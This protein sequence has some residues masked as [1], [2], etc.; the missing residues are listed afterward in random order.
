MKTKLVLILLCFF[1]F[2]G[3]SQDRN[4]YSFTSPA[5]APLMNTYPMMNGKPSPLKCS[6]VGGISYEQVAKPDANFQISRFE[7]HYGSSKADG[8]RL[9]LS[10]NG[11]TV[12][13]TCFDWQ[14]IPIAKF[15]NS[16]VTA[17]F[18]YFGKLLDDSLESIVLG[19]GGHILNYH[20]F[21]NNTLLGMR[22]MDM[23]L[24]YMYNFVSDLPKLNN[25]YILGNGESIPDINANRLGINNFRREIRNIE[26]SL[27]QNFRSYIITDFNRPVIISLN[28]DSL[29]LSGFPYYYCWR[30]KDENPAF[31]SA[32][33]RSRIAQNYKGIMAAQLQKNP[34]FSVRS[35]YME[36]LI[37]LAEIY[38]PYYNLY[39]GG[40]FVD[41]VNLPNDRTFRVDFLDRYDNS[42]LERLLME[43]SYD[44]E[45]RSIDFLEEFSNRM[46][47]VDLLQNTNPAVWNANVNI[48][49]YAAFF[50]YV[51]LNFPLKWNHFLTEL[52]N[53]VPQPVVE[54]YTVMYEPVTPTIPKQ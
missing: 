40:T 6:S 15:A 4:D 49:R 35:F 44:M 39:P 16:D 42:S 34:D 9:S 21:F 30:Y 19:N 29:Q 28:N 11:T 22:L 54:T 10:I 32:A 27:N 53:I 7:I 48:M 38:Q 36:S 13:A 52:E 43:T 18:T 47:N 24:L 23:D 12:S 51:K 20:P 2:I 45:A 50:R 31:D 8:Q 1:H 14:L 25:A 46:S 3:Q 37:S 5:A 41:L 17:C 33:V 26:V